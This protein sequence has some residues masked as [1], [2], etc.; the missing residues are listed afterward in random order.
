MRDNEQLQSVVFFLSDHLM[1]VLEE[2][3]YIGSLSYSSA[4]VSSDI[5]AKDILN[6][7][8]DFHTFLDQIKS[9]EFLLVTK[10]TQARHWALHLRNLDPQFR[11]IIDLFTV[12][13]DI[14]EDMGSVLGPDDEAVFNG[15]GQPQYFIESRQLLN[16]VENA[17]GAPVK[18]AADET[19]ML[20]GRIR[21]LELVRVVTGFLESL[22]THYGLKEAPTIDSVTTQRTAED[23]ESLERLL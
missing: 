10:L 19:F 15:A 13:T 14:C 23:S 6:R 12:S 9:H 4:P 2:S 21:L 16:D 3:D 7:L 22:N 11:P 20:G 17:D 8:D 5:S 1:A 18:I